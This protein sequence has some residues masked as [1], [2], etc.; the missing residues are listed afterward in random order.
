[1]A[2]FDQYIFKKK[3]FSDVLEEIYNRSKTKETQIIGLIDDLRN[4]IQNTAD[5]LTLAPLMKSYMDVAVKNDDMLIKMLAIVQK[6]VTRGDDSGDYNIS[7]EEREQLLKLAQEN[8]A[9]RQIAKGN[10]IPSA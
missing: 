6:G 4:M 2:D 8:T 10:Q 7:E 5:A 1:M 9:T 3:K